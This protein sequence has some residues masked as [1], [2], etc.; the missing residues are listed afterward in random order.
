MEG[1]DDYLSTSSNPG[2]EHAWFGRE[3]DSALQL[4][5]RQEITA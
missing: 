4:C 3:A 1:A 2:A 5:G